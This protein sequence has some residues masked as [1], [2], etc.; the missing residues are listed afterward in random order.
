LTDSERQFS[1]LLK[2]AVPDVPRV[3]SRCADTVVPEVPSVCS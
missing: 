2:C 1:G 3:C